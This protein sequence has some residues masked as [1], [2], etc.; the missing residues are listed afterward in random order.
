MR[1]K[2]IIFKT[3]VLNI[4]IVTLNA[5]VK[6]HQSKFRDC[7]SVRWDRLTR[8]GRMWGK[9]HHAINNQKKA[10]VNLLISDKV[11]FQ[12]VLLGIQR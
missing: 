3:V 6:T 5:M 4:S 12:R 2:K 1:R 7:Q 9:V 10:I 8:S 11:N